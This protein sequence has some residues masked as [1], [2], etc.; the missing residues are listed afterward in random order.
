MQHSGLLI[1]ILFTMP[2]STQLQGVCLGSTIIALIREKLAS[3]LIRAFQ[4]DFK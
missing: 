3:S 1:S 4:N 2:L